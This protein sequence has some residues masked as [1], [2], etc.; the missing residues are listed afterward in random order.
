MVRYRY[1][2]Q[3]HMAKAECERL[4]AEL[5]KM[6]ATGG[7]GAAAAALLAPTA[8]A[9]PAAAPVPAAAAGSLATAPAPTGRQLLTLLRRVKINRVHKP[10]LVPP[11]VFR[12][13]VFL[14]TARL[15]G[16]TA[17]GRFP[18]ARINACVVGRLRRGDVRGNKGGVRVIGSCA[19]IETT[20]AHVARPFAPAG[21]GI[22]KTSCLDF[23]HTEVS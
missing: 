4:R 19:R 6:A 5:S 12:W 10:V 11:F 14:L 9:A 22:I 20:D 16:V 13:G 3:Y 21:A 2:S 15:K 23:G 8:A 1:W 17:A 7:P 18:R